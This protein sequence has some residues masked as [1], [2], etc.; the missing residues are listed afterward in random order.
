MSDETLAERAGAAKAADLATVIY[1]SGTT[2]PPQGLRAHATRTCSPT[3]QR[4]HG[5][6]RRDPRDVRTRRTLLFLPLAHVF[7]R[8]IEVGCLEAGIVLGHCADMNNLLPDLASFQPTFVLA[9]PRVFEKVYNGAE[10]AR[11]PARARARSSP[12]PRRTAVAYSEALDAPGGPALRAAR[13]ARPVRPAGLR[14]AARRAR[15]QGASGRSPA[16]RRSAPRL[17]HFFR[18]VGVTILEGYGLTETTAP[19]SVNR[20]GPAEDRHRRPAAARRRRAHRRRRRGAG[21]R[22]VD[23]PRLLAE[24]GRPPRRRSPPTAGSAP[25]TSASS[26]TRASSRITGRKKEIIV[27]AG[28]K[29]VAPAVLE[30]R[31]RMHALII[32]QCM[33]VGD[34]RPFVGGADHDRPRGVRAVEGAARQAGRRDRRRPAR[35]PGPDAEV[36]AAVDDANKAVSRAESI[37]QVPDPRRGLHPGAGAPVRQARHQARSVLAK[38]FAG[39]IEALYSS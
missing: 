36:Q 2:G 10:A 26:T 3:S 17:G 28:G 7:A 31:L 35:R 6:A 30:D 5:A 34:G 4:V 32:G 16:A 8:V 15:R 14:Q 25:A 29:N 33:V 9:V 1:T 11:P 24:R 19:V 21:P 22:Q 12:A 20:P 23:L 13:R 27:T 18:G 37:Q 38:E 39:E